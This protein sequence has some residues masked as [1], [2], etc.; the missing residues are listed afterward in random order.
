[1]KKLVI[2]KFES[3]DGKIFDTESQC[4]LHESQM[5]DVAW[6]EVFAGPDLTEGR[7]GPKSR[8][9]IAVHAKSSHS[10]FAE[11]WC[12]KEYGSAVAFCQGVFG[13][14]AVIPNWRV[15]RLENVNMSLDVNILALIEERCVSKKMWDGHS[16]QYS[17]KHA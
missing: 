10:M 3:T 7:H 12:Y 14:N 1:M 15:D 8:G 11:H 2:E 16:L 9:Y 4:V 17:P 6:F 5:K 13:S